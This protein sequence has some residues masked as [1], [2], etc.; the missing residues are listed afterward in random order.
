MLCTILSLA[1]LLQIGLCSR[2]EIATRSYGSLVT[3]Q[4]A[5]VVC[6]KCQTNG[7]SPYACK[8]ATLEINN[9]DFPNDEITLTNGECFARNFSNCLASIC[10]SPDTTIH[11]KK[12]DAISILEDQLLVECVEN[13]KDGIYF[14]G[15]VSINLTAISST[16]RKRDFPIH[17]ENGNDCYS[18]ENEKRINPP[19]CQTVIDLMSQSS[20]TGFLDVPEYTCSV[21]RHG[22]CEGWICNDVGWV[23]SV[24]ESQ[25]AADLTSQ[26]YDVCSINGLAGVW[27]GQGTHV[28]IHGRLRTQSS[29]ENHQSGSGCYRNNNSK[30]INPSDC[31]IV[32]DMMSQFSPTGYIDISKQ[33]CRVFTHE[34][35]QGWLCNDQDRDISVNEA[36]LAFDLTT[37]IYNACN[38]YGLAGEW[39][40]QG[41]T[42]E[43]HGNGMAGGFENKTVPRAESS[44][45]RRDASDKDLQGAARCFNTDVG[46]VDINPPDCHIVIDQISQSSANGYIDFRP[47]EVKRFTFGTCMATLTNALH[48]VLSINEATLAFDLTSQVYLPCSTQKTAGLWSDGTMD[49]VISGQATPDNVPISIPK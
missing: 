9:H 28:A 37:S 38:I 3:C 11:V 10:G 40:G 18:N 5:P 45:K 46:Y 2:L 33:S 1:V 20:P 26:V 25:L 13:H 16:L 6:C 36:K 48:T 42:V 47:K 22:T 4:P 14:D 8:Y 12:T 21:F 49:I 43:I 39:M 23:I 32:I 19:D 24:N 17:H 44:L 31:H 29:P 41:A 30:A 15:Q 35:C 7:A 27:T 34:T